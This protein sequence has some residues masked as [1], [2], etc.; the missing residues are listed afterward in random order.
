MARPA[1]LEEAEAEAQ[2]LMV[3]SPAVRRLLFAGGVVSLIVGLIG[4]LIPVFPTS[5]FLLITGAL[6]ARS[7]KRFYVWLLIHRWLGPPV[8]DFRRR[9]C[10]ELRYKL[11]IAGLLAV[12][13]LPAVRIGVVVVALAM[14]APVLLIPTCPGAST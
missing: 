1:S 12:S 2:R 6:W 10:L 14:A 5:P 11:G 4:L 7:S 8:A 13:E 9:G 3:R